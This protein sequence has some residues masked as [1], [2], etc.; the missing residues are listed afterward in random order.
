MQKWTIDIDCPIYR[1]LAIPWVL[2]EI[3]QSYLRGNGL[4]GIYI[5]RLE[6]RY[7]KRDTKGD[8]PFYYVRNHKG[9]PLSYLI[10]TYD[11]FAD[12][13]KYFIGDSIEEAARNVGR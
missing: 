3:N 2:Y 7:G 5:H 1:K 4:L 13:A 9:V 8:N 6:N 10:P 11:W 12:K